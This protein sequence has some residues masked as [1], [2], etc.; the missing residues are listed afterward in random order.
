MDREI[1]AVA[2]DIS[3]LDG[4]EHLKEEVLAPVPEPEPYEYEPPT[5]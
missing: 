4:A 5:W 3:A 2:R 1:L